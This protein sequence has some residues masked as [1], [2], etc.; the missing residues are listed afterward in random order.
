MNS[1]WGKLYNYSYIT[2]YNSAGLRSEYTMTGDAMGLDFIKRDE[3]S[4]GK[5][6]YEVMEQL[7]DAVDSL[8]LGLY[9]KDG[10]SFM[11][12]NQVTDN[13]YNCGYLFNGVGLSQFTYGES[14]EDGITYTKIQPIEFYFKDNNLYA[15]YHMISY[16]YEKEEKIESAYKEWN[17]IVQVFQKNAE[18]YY[19]KEFGKD[20]GNQFF[21]LQITG[22]KCAYE[23]GFVKGKDAGM[24]AV[25]AVEL[26]AVEDK[27]SF[28]KGEWERHEICFALNLKT[29]EITQQYGVL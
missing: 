3:N 17:E 20:Y 12:I 27:Y 23:G 28:E 5:K 24:F 2:D 14:E 7:Q 22:I 4:S 13:K 1:G 18:K 19:K 26:S 15:I 16:Q 29:G 21:H 11:A 6:D 10:N 25:P 9:D 8:N